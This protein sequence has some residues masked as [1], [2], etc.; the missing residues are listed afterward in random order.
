MKNIMRLFSKYE[1]PVELISKSFTQWKSETIQ[2]NVALV[3]HA[4][5]KNGKWYVNECTDTEFHPDTFE[6]AQTVLRDA[7][8]EEKTIYQQFINLIDHLR[9]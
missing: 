6:L 7:T 2:V 3:N 4:Y 8:D 1:S 5:I 9:D